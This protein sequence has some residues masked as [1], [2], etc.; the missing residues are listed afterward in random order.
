MGGNNLPGDIALPYFILGRCSGY[1]IGAP[2]NMR[3]TIR[4]KLATNLVKIVKS[5]LSLFSCACDPEA[6]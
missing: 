5:G 4:N 1:E 6:A 3:A 2:E